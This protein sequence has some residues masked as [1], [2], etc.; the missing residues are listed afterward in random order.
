[1]DELL[2]QYINM[3]NCP[4]PIKRL[5]NGFYLFGTKKIYAKILNGKL[6]IRVGGG[7]MV[8]DQFIA[9]YAEPELAKLENMAMKH[10]VND[11]R[12]LDL[13]EIVLGTKDQYGNRSSP[14]R[15]NTAMAGS[16]KGV[17]SGT[18]ILTK[19]SN[20]GMNGTKRR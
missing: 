10:G 8:A 15:R 3:A 7:Y 17:K 9:T 4:I 5:G 12:E 14:T 13:E 11:W 19:K 18:Q 6:V 1:M 16:P 2:A 20:T